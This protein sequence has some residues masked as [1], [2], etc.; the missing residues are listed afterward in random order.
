MSCD[1]ATEGQPPQGGRPI[2]IDEMLAALAMALICVISLA[3]VVVRYL[4][5]VSFAF[6]EEF[7]VFLLVFMTLT[8]S[9]V[10]FATD[11]HIRIVF[12]RDLLPRRLRRLADAA[13]LLLAGLLF[14]MVL[15]YGALFAWDEWEYEETSPGLGLPNWIY[16]V[17]L[18]VLSGWIL[19]RIG[20]RLFRLFRH[21][22]DA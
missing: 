19:A 3:N 17:W 8:G 12:F 18:P 10:A 6:T 22:G 2:R 9:A 20:G 21:G 4:T 5:D 15:Y 1:P 14:A 16:T 13:A 11:G 7:S